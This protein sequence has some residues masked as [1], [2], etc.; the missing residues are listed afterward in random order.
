MN[1]VKC[2]IINSID[3]L[4]PIGDSIGAVAFEREVVFG[5]LSIGVLDSNA[6]FN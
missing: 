5:I 6:T 2:N 1:R 4:E 3:V